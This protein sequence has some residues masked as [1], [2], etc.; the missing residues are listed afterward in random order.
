M[1]KQPLLTRT[2]FRE[3]TFQRDNH[4]CVMCGVGGQLDAHHIIERRLWSDGGYYLDNGVTL[5]DP[6]CH[7]LAEETLI[8]CEVLREKAGIKSTL[9]PDHLD[10]SE[11]WDKWGNAYLPNG[12]RL[13]GELFHDESVQKILTPVLSEFT[14]R[15]KYPRTRHLPWSPG[16]SADDCRMNNT[17]IYDGMEVVVTVKM[18]GENT[19]IYRDGIHARSLIYTPHPSRTKI[20]A[21]AAELGRELT[22]TT[23]LCGEN[24]YATHSIHYKNLPGHFLLFSVWDRNVALSW[25]ETLEWAEMLD[26]PV[27]PVLYRGIWDKKLV[28]GLYEPTFHGNPCEGYVVRPASS[29]T[30][31]QFKTHVSKYVRKNHIQTDEHWMNAKIVPNGLL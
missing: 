11:R 29:F 2:Q 13:Q 18:D 6:T 20:K 10:P 31:S 8:T 9:L 3:S 16:A 15:V 23:R 28:Q 25:D 24:V 17:F 4:R 27:V 1:R 26:L 19:T 30:L 12:Q 21:L 5:C 7:T 22:D 14:N